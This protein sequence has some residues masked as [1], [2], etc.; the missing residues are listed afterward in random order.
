MAESVLYPLDYQL[1]LARI[2]REKMQPPAMQE[3]LS[4]LSRSDFGECRQCGR[5]IPF[6]EILADPAARCCK[7][8]S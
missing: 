2:I 8:C 4:R 1:T 6:L 5:V 3:A 7:A